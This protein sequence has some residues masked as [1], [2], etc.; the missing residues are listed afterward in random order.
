[1]KKKPAGAQSELES[2]FTTQP[3]AR[4]PSP[5]LFFPSSTACTSERD[6]KDAS[7]VAK[8]IGIELVRSTTTRRTSRATRRQPHA[9]SIRQGGLRQTVL[10]FCFRNV[11][12]AI[13]RWADPQP[14][15]PVQPTRQIRPPITA[16]QVSRRLLLGHGPLRARGS[17]RRRSLRPRFAAQTQRHIQGPDI[18]SLPSTR[19]HFLFPFSL[20]SFRFPFVSPCLLHAPL[21]FAVRVTCFACPPRSSAQRRVPPCRPPQISCSPACC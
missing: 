11:H 5:P 13:R 20:F 7:A 1:M 21:E 9:A 18:L 8:A 17:A 14:R 2:P 16:R 19:S 10:E 15:H 6:Y 3:P 4:H 12:P